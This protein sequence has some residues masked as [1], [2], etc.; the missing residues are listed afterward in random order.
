MPLEQV[1]APV[2]RT[3]L[4]AAGLIGDGLYGVDVKVV[5]RR[6]HVIEVNDNPNIDAGFE[7]AQLKDSLYLRVMDV[8][9]RRIEQGKRGTVWH[10]DRGEGLRVADD[11]HASPAPGRGAVSAARACSA[12]WAGWN[13][14]GVR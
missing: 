3:A 10:R 14:S 4:K 8:F 6:V 9:S 13:S 12:R 7:D 5:G 1:P 11:H 2:L